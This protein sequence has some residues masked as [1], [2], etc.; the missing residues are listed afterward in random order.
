MMSLGVFKRVLCLFFI[1]FYIP[2]HAVT[3]IQLLHTSDIHSQWD[4]SGSPVGLGGIA[5]L[6]TLSDQL[7]GQNENTLMLDSGDWT[8]G[9]IFFTLKSGESSHQIME[10]LNYDA[11]VLGNHE[12]LIGPNDLY[13]AFKGSGS[14]L[15]VLGANI[16]MKRLSG[17][18]KLGDFIKPYIIKNVGGKKIAILGLSTFEIIY[19]A[20]FEPVE[21]QSAAKIG[22]RIAKYLKE[23]QKVDVVIALTHIG[24]QSDRVL[25]EISPHID[26]ILG[27]H[28]HV[29]FSEPLYVEN[30]PIIHIGKWGWYLGQYEIEIDDNNKVKLSKHKIHQIDSS[31]KE[32][33]K[34]Q[35]MVSGM[36]K[37][38]EQKMGPIFSDKS[39]FSKVN[40]NLNH[41]IIENAL[42]NWTVDAYRE[43]IQ[44][45]LAIDN[46]NY[47]SRPLYAG[48]SNT[49][50]LF[51]MLP[52][53]YSQSSDKT[54]T[55]KSF[56]VNGFILKLLSN[57]MFAAGSGLKV[58]NATIQLDLDESVAP[59]KK[60]KIGNR[61][62]SPLKTY[63]VA[64]TDGVLQALGMLRLFGFDLGVKNIKDSGQEAWRVVA[65]KLKQISPI[66]SEKAKWQGRI[67][68]VQP[69][70]HISSEDL[71]FERISEQK[72]KVKFK[73][74]NAG[75]QDANLGLIRVHIDTTPQNALDQVW[76]KF[77]INSGA[78]IVLKGGETRDFSFIWD[79]NQ[80]AQAVYPIWISTAASKDEKLM[81]NN[82]LR[83]YLNLSL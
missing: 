81:A 26:L 51:N 31:I 35:G 19:D 20:F 13:Q 29:L 56:Q 11:I 79:I 55:V 40:L 25:A 70:I 82:R 48:Y 54:W 9:S 62:I 45:D 75:Y 17:D 83:T 2:S 78:V 73:I 7:R 77:E 36:Q 74:T 67:R 1:C 15:P 42:G 14:K 57:L 72:L 6:K 52:H 64:G 10:A 63:T 24:V 49:V 61:E 16:D 65:N 38:L 30:K 50:D 5:R 46:A 76:D 41:E 47:A 58:S 34:I 32:D 37:L 43:S 44:A 12:W 27:G 4:N 71:V 22:A 21:L 59:I 8:E 3:K 69:D 80:R 33:L 23:E 18:I 60:F 66:D 39:V 68:S 28:T 53:T